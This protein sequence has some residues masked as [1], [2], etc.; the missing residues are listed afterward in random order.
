MDWEVDL[1]RVV[2]GRV[3]RSTCTSLGFLEDERRGADDS[4]TI[5][6]LLIVCAIGFVI[7]SL[8]LAVSISSTL[9]IA[10]WIE[11]VIVNWT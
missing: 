2:V 1:E 8:W 9:F 11:V 7:A 5:Y 6:L 4:S 10:S 3:L